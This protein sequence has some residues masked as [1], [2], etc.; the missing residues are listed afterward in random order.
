MKNV[1]IFILVV[2][3]IAGAIFIVLNYNQEKE[4]AEQ[5][6]NTKNTTEDIT[7]IR[8]YNIIKDLNKTDTT[9]QYKYYVIDQFQMDSPIVIKVKNSYNL[10]ENENYEFTFEGRKTDGKEYT[11]QEI[12]E[13]F[14]I[15]D[16]KETDK[17]GLEQIQD[18]I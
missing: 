2:I 7:F 5:I 10:I 13:D 11:I 3:I 17:E 14:N 6:E 16:I 9:G 12:F 18:I 4:Q 8:T 1:I 15:V